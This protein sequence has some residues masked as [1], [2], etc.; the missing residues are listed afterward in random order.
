LRKPPTHGPY[1]PK[2]TLQLNAPVCGIYDFAATMEIEGSEQMGVG[3]EQTMWR[4]V[5]M[6]AGRVVLLVIYTGK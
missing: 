2:F 4:G 6:A 1:P 3:I 5:K